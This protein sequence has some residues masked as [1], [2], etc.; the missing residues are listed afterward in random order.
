[1]SW[2]CPLDL[3]CDIVVELPDI[4]DALGLELDDEGD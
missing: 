2:L 4:G 1:L 3:S